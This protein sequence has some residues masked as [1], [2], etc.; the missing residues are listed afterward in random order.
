MDNL[1]PPARSE[2]MSRIRG[3]DTAPE[4]RVRR[5]THSLGLR[6]RLHYPD[7]GIRRSLSTARETTV[8]VVNAE[9]PED[10]LREF[11]ADF[12]AFRHLERP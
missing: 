2:H 8:F 4:L 1:S 10:F 6:F 3:K 11:D 7:C 9:R 12:S 5:I